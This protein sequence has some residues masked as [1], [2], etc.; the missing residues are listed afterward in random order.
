ML[1]PDYHLGDFI[2][3]QRLAG[4]QFGLQP[5]CPVPGNFAKTVFGVTIHGG[6][7][8]RH[9][10]LCRV[11][12]RQYERVEKAIANAQKA[13]DADAV[14]RLQTY[15]AQT[16]AIIRASERRR[17]ANMKENVLTALLPPIISMIIGSGLFW[18]F[19]GFSQNRWSSDN[20]NA[21]EGSVLRSARISSS[22]F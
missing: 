21:F 20:Q 4:F 5:P 10:G 11:E 13:Q 12:E 8:E 2:S 7:V 19:S 1:E 9:R 18:A 3:V 17:V 16:D 14:K 22:G 15:Q 6:P